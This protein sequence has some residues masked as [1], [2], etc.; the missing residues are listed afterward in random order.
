[1]AP[2]LIEGKRAGT[3]SSHAYVKEQKTFSGTELKTYD[4][5]RSCT[6][7]QQ[8]TTAWISSHIIL[9][10]KPKSPEQTGLFSSTLEAMP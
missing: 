5:H 3:K 1:L 6:I 10:Q 2:E 7:Y 8:Y 4:A 9:N